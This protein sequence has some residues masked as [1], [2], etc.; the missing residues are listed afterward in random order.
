[1]VFFFFLKRHSMLEY[2]EYGKHHVAGSP[3][4]IKRSSV[5]KSATLRDTTMIYLR[6]MFKYA[7][8]NTITATDRFHSHHRFEHSWKGCLEAII[9]LCYRKVSPTVCLLHL[10]SHYCSLPG[11]KRS[12]RSSTDCLRYRNVYISTSLVLLEFLR[13]KRGSNNPSKLGFI[14]HHQHTN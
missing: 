8:R 2:T 11:W 3:G 4:G 10:Q 14:T 5:F 13:W 7:P 12:G 6:V 9:N 1:M